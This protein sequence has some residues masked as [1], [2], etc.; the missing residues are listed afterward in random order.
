MP[1]QLTRKQV[2]LVLRRATELEQRDETALDTLT[3]QDLERVADELGMSRDA[4]NQALAESRAGALV[5]EEDRTKLD[6]LFG[7]RIIEA[8]RFVPGSV[9][10][11]RGSVD[12]FLQEQGFQQKR[13]LGQ[14]Q[15]WESGR[16]WRTRMRRAMRAGAYRLPRD[17]EI[18]VRV[19]EVPGGPHPV[20]VALR[21]DATRARAT[22]VGA[23][24]ASLV[25][26]TAVIAG[27]AILLPMPTELLAIGGGGIAGLGG[28]W[29]SRSSYRSEC[30]RLTVAVERFLD[31]LEHEP[32]PAP[33]KAPD[34]IKRIVD[35]LSREWWR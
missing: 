6:R 7:G 3:P 25:A 19:A 32:P 14:A 33:Q 12:Q 4:L 21:V 22:R 24:T 5:A 31:F 16:D 13:N 35:F 29:L 11:V 2:E 10:N 30:E 23:A 26:A 15:V 28:S 27:G 34:P 20:L 9:A 18:E 17:V 8:R 1:E